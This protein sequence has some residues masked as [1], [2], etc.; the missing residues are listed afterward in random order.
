LQAATAGGIEFAMNFRIRIASA[1]DVPA[2]H[3]VRQAVR[4]N[5]LSDPQQIS[6][7]SYLPYI[8]AGGIWVAETDAGVVGFA[9]VD[10]AGRSIWALF[11]DPEV[12]GAGIGRALH[13]RMLKWAQEQGMDGLTLVTEKGTRAARFYRRAGWAENGTTADGE[14][15]FELRLEG[16]L[17]THS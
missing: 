1:A 10:A 17:P 9:A 12:E 2:M 6:E 4:E 5:R 7:A 16:R 3:R 14:Q 15:R 11:I 8:A 13:H